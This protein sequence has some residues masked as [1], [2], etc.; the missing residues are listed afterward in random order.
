MPF[1]LIR[2][3]KIIQNVWRSKKWYFI[4]IFIGIIAVRN[5]HDFLLEQTFSLMRNVFSCNPNKNLCHH[6]DVNDVHPY[7]IWIFF[8]IF[9]DMLN[10]YY[11]SCT[12]ALTLYRENSRMNVSK[13]FHSV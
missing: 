9:R 7:Q 13:Q 1:Y 10:T 5:K 11:L 3:L 4:Q 6:S 12:T 8:C 2:T